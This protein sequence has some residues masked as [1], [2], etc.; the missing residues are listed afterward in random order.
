[1]EFGWVVLVLPA[2]ALLETLSIR[3]GTTRLGKAILELFRL[4]GRVGRVCSEARVPW[5]GPGP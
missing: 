2:V 5:F 3:A 1:M 4:G